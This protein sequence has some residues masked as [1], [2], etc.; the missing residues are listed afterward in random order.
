NV[1]EIVGSGI[2]EVTGGEIDE[3]EDDGDD[4][5][6]DED[7]ENSYNTDIEPYRKILGD[8]ESIIVNS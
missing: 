1:V 7:E 2:I 4:D 3:E 6:D 5:D 8:G